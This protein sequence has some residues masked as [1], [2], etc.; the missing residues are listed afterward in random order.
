V[1]AFAIGGLLVLYL[2]RVQAWPLSRAILGRP[3]A[4]F[5]LAMLAL[6]LT[7]SLRDIKPF[8]YALLFTWPMLFS[9]SAAVMIMSGLGGGQRGFA[10][11]WMRRLGVVSYT[12]YLFQQFVLGPWQATYGTDFTWPAW[13]VAVAVAI[14][15][16][17]LWYAYG[18]RPLTDV[19]AR[20]FPRVASGEHPSGRPLLRSAEGAPASAR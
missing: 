18:E 4:S 20:W 14:V 17:P 2:E 7:G 6:I 8:S 12:V 11:E 1:E 5:V 10:P 16:V 15:G 13:S 3:A 19:G 9:L